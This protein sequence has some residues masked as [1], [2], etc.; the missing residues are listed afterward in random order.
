MTITEPMLTPER[1]D[2]AAVPLFTAF[3]ADPRISPV[4]ARPGRVRSEFALPPAAL[5]VVAA[6]ESTPALPSRSAVSAPAGEVDWEE[7]ARLRVLASKRLTARLGGGTPE[8]GNRRELGRAVVLEVVQEATEAQLSLTGSTWTPADQQ[9]MAKAVFDLMYGLG[10]FQTLVDRDDVEDIVVIGHDRVFLNLVDGRNV[11][12]PPVA[13]SDKELEK[14]LQDLAAAAD[15]P[16]TFSDA[17]PSLNL[18]LEGARLAA[19]MSVV[20]RP[21]VVIRRHRL[22]RVTLDD[23][24]GFGTVTPV[25]ASFL[26]AAV[27]ARLSIVVS[28]AQGDGK[29]TMLRALCHEIEPREVIG[30]FETERELGLERLT[31]E[32]PRVISWEERPGSGELG[33]DGRPVNQFTLERALWSSFRYILGRQVVGEVRGA[34]VAQMILAMESGSG[35]MSTTHA[36]SAGLAMEKLVSCAMQSGEFTRDS[37][38]MKLARLIHLVVHMRTCVITGRDGQS[39]KLRVVDEI[40]AIRP[41]EAGVGYATDTVFRRNGDAPATPTLLPDH[42][43]RLSTHGFAVSEFLAEAHRHGGVA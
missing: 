5:H 8:E 37:A 33:P 43:Q 21:T 30:L 19:S 11:P 20:H 39:R 13:S 27:R 12:G 10:R 22:V 3:G 38:V 14:F 25:M 32:H 35:S 24:V 1:P 34:E 7:A 16:R 36:E 9:A 28:G 31:V 40:V 29:T 6:A 2:L 4:T 26:A 41:G 17:H 15:P 23:L 18:N 42:L